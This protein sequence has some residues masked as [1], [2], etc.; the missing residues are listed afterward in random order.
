MRPQ[1][2]P[3][4]GENEPLVLDRIVLKPSVQTCIDD[5]TVDVVAGRQITSLPGAKDTDDIQQ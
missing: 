3:P 5:V 1:Q 4:D 2:I